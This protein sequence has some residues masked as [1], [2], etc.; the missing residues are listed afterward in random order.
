MDY[1]I[2]MHCCTLRLY[3]HASLSLLL[4][5]QLNPDREWPA[6]SPAADDS[7]NAA[8]ECQ[9][10]NCIETPRSA[11]RPIYFKI[12]VRAGYLLR[13]GM[14]HTPH[15]IL[16]IYLLYAHWLLSG[17]ASRKRKETTHIFYFQASFSLPERFHVTK[18]VLPK[19]S[20][21]GGLAAGKCWHF[22]LLRII[23]V[24][25]LGPFAFC[26]ALPSVNLTVYQ[27]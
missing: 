18:Y 7:Q 22:P 23:V 12:P 8:T 26:I 14:I 25:Y 5:D 11:F 6:V 1:C 2:Y 10:N 24:T 21:V 17:L 15:N 16:S 19:F 3:N 27:V 20:I 13:H 4:T 9:E